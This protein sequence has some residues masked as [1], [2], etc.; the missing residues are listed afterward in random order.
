M[1]ANA[2]KCFQEL[3]EEGN[4]G[5]I[6]DLIE[7]GANPDEPDDKGLVPLK[8]ACGSDQVEC[9]RVLLEMKANVN[10]VGRGITG[11]ISTA[12]HIACKNGCE[13][14]IKAL[15]AAGANPSLRN[16]RDQLP[17]DTAQMFN[18]TNAVNII[19]MHLEKSVK[20]LIK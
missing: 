7:F 18:Q 19:K 3:I 1:L 4:A 2:G 12:L 6:R 10:L 13:Q 14:N 5:T 17:S 15:L 16:G 20:D 8:A 9:V 11:H